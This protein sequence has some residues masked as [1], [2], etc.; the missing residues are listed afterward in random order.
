MYMK[1]PKGINVVDVNN[2][3]RSTL[4]GLALRL[5][6]SLYGL[7]QSPQLWN[8]ELDRF[9]RNIGFKRADAETS[10]YYSYNKVNGKFVIVLSEVDDLVVT[11]NDDAMIEAFHYSLIKSFGTAKDDGTKDAKSIAWEPISSFLGI[12]IDYDM[13]AG[14]LAMNVKSKIDNLFADDKHKHALKSIGTAN[15]PQPTN[16]NDNDYCEEG[17]WSHLELHLKK[18]YASIVGTIIYLH[19]TCRPDITF[20]IGQLAR[21]MHKPTRVHV[22]KLKCLLKYLNSHRGTPLVYRASGT[23]C[24]THMRQMDQDDHNLFSIVSSYENHVNG[25][26]II[27]GFSDA[28]FARAHCEQRRST[29][30][31]CFFVFHNCVCWKSKLQPLTA[32]STHEAELI[33]LSYA[34]QEGV[35]LRRLIKELHFAVRAPKMKHYVT[36]KAGT[37]AEAPRDAEE[38]MKQLPPTPVFG[39]NKG[40]TQTVNNPMSTAQASK[41]L[42]TRYFVTRDYIR[43]KKL[44]VNFIRTHVNVS[45]FFTKALGQPVFTEFKDILMGTTSS[46]H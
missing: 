21:G 10:L 30:G 28:D 31:Y 15:L 39:D 38:F 12:D 43:E 46:A 22:N 9:F 4:N 41:A 13:K 17:V 29:S 23:P 3:R 35:W 14:T 20:A 1:L 6:R 42:D 25:F 40:T 45:D 19:T 32:G 16:F 33:A 7:K 18:N 8:Q 5:L 11:G 26:D 24:E 2:P 37:G 44:R 27:T 36:K 34:S